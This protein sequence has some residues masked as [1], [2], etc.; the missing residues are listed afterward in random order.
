MAS[1]VTVSAAAPAATAAAQPGR[2]ARQA[3]HTRVT[4][5]TASGIRNGTR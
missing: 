5:Y 2:R 1:E 3:A 4:P